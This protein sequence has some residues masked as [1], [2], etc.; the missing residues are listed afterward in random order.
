VT[1]STLA[2][3]TI[4]KQLP[5][6]IGPEDVIVIDNQLFNQLID[7]LHGEFP[8]ENTL[9]LNRLKFKNRD[10]IPSRCVHD[11]RTEDQAQMQ[12][13][14][15]TLNQVNNDNIVLKS[16]GAELCTAAIRVATEYDG[17]HRLLLAV[18]K[19]IKAMADEHGRGDS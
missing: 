14:A 18:A 3:E 8:D 19:F 7:D 12:V 10:V 17:T 5:Q 13:V 15:A 1:E 2:R 6:S 16:V 4:A 9:Q 11:L